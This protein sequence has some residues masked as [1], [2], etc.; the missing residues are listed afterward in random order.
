MAFFPGW[1][2]HWDLYLGFGSVTCDTINPKYSDLYVVV[3]F[4]T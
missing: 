1:V 4:L 2:F 3:L